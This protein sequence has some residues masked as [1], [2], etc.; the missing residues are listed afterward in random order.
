MM[1]RIALS[2]C[3]LLEMASLGACQNRDNS[4]S[5]TYVGNQERPSIDSGY[6]SSD[7]DWLEF[8]SCWKGEIGNRLASEPNRSTVLMGGLG[9]SLIGTDEYLGNR[10][11][12]E[13]FRGDKGRS[14]PKS[15]RD[16]AAVTGGAWVVESSGDGMDVRNYGMLL[17]TKDIAK[18]KDIDFANWNIWQEAI[19]KN[20]AREVSPEMYYRYG[21]DNNP[22]ERQDSAQFRWKH[23]NDLIK[24][25][26]LEQGTVLL[27]N[28]ME[29]SSDGEWEAWLLSPKL[30]GA[31][32]YRSFAELMQHI[33]HQDIFMRG[34]SFVSKDKLNAGCSKLI[35]T[36]ANK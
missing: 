12:V 22:K 20:S 32:R 1:K 21:F 33:A 15:Y 27:I 36:A 10:K 35:I 23:L 7:K 28:P 2:L 30:P 25:G 5:K 3:F 26:E 17:P 31:N 34:G 11:F 9:I 14:L 18:F 4:D 16:F 6:V 24:V 13:E 8:L 29:I 19:G